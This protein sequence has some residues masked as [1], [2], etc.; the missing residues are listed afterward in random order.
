M[1]IFF[2]RF[3]SRQDFGSLGLSPAQGKTMHGDIPSS[4]AVHLQWFGA[5]GW[6]INILRQDLCDFI[7]TSENSKQLNNIS[8]VTIIETI[9]LCQK[10]W[11][12]LDIKT[13]EQKSGT[14][15]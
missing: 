3:P 7:S 9:F 15:T 6:K 11:Q 12:H 2:T 4:G 5:F 14:L 8:I 13:L 1:H 10:Y